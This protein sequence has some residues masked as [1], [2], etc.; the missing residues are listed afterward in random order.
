MNDSMKILYEEH[1][2]ISKAAEK[3][4]SAKNLIGN[5]DQAYQKIITELISFFRNYADGYHHFKEENILFPEM[6][7]K[8]ELLSDGIIFEMVDNHADF[9]EML[10]SAEENLKQKNFSTTHQILEKYIK[11]LLEHIAVE[12][13]ELFQMTESLFTEDELE[14]IKFRFEDYDHELGINE[15][16]ALENVFSQVRSS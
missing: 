16:V 2:I 15:K 1:D 11:A 7:K 3:V 9:R 8:N 4:N 12:N 13:E 5:D 6:C 14:R 10:G